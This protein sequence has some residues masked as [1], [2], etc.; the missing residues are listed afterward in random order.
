MYHYLSFLFFYLS[1]AK[2]LHKVDSFDQ[3][4]NSL[5]VWNTMDAE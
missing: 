4:K 5:W 2:E 1:Y 3:K